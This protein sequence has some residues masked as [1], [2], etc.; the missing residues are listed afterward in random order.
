MLDY[1]HPKWLISVDNLLV[2]TA[3]FLIFCM[4]L[5]LF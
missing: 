1:G 4:L 3:F 5:E 2:F